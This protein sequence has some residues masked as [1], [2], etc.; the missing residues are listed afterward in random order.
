VELSIFVSVIILAMGIIVN[1]GLSYSHNQEVAMMAFKKAMKLAGEIS[2]SSRYASV[3]L[4]ADKAMADVSSLW[5]IAPRSPVVSS[6]SGIISND[7]YA[8]MDGIDEELPRMTYDINGKV[9]KLRTAVFEIKP[10]LNPRRK[11]YKDGWN[12][13]GICWEWQYPDSKKNKLDNGTAWDIDNDQEEETIV[14]LNK[15][16]LVMDSQDGEL[17]MTE[18][19]PKL[20]NGLLSETN[21]TNINRSI[22][23]TAQEDARTATSTR[24]RYLQ[25][26][27]RY[28]RLNP[29]A[30]DL[31]NV[32]VMVDQNNQNC[33]GRGQPCLEEEKDEIVENG[34]ETMLI[35]R[36]RFATDRD[37]YSWLRE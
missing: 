30:E 35:I 36:S 16:S 23:T 4:V 8:K 14:K 18:D 29:K 25:I 12:G 26:V 7:L 22:L 21:T 10:L 31:S 3:V 34:N 13:E 2:G 15:P 24:L 19:D 17:D 20:R 32:T 6:S 11:N 27:E 9:Y 37:A 28:V 1:Y 5:G 33:Y